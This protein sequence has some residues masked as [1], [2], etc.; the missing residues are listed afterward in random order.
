MLRL[1]LVCSSNGGGG[2]SSSSSGGGSSCSSSG[3]SSSSS[4]SVRV[5]VT[6]TLCTLLECSYI[7]ISFLHTFMCAYAF[8]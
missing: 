2:G 7:S 6:F 8:M 1:G 3:G 5:T 4:S